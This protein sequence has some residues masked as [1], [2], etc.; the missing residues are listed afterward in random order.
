[1]EER[2]GFNSLWK[3]RSGGKFFLYQGENYYYDN[4]NNRLYLMQ[5]NQMLP[6]KIQFEFALE[7]LSSGFLPWE[8]SLYSIR[9]SD[10]YTVKDFA[11]GKAVSLPFSKEKLEQQ[12]Q[13][14]SYNM[15]GTAGEKIYQ[16]FAKECRKGNR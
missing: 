2:G 14:V 8:R 10:F 6:L 1:M 3:K 7:E 11:E 4:R 16:F 12:L 15:D 5:E 9:E 13:T